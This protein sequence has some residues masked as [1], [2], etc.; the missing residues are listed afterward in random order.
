MTEAGVPL[1]VLDSFRLDG[2][3]A[4][5][6]GAGSGIGLAVAAALAEAGADVACLEVS[7]A[8]A[9]RARAQVEDLG[10][11]SVACV[12]DVAEEAAVEA[13][14][15]EAEEVLGSV[16]IVFANAGIAGDGGGIEALDLEGWRRV[17]DVDLTGTLL[18]VRAAARRMVSRGYGKIVVTGSMYSLRGDP[19]FGSHAYTA[20]KSGVV[21][22]TRSSAITL[23]PHGVRINAILPGYIRTRLADG[24]LFAEDADAV[25]LRRRV[26]ERLPL[27]RV[28][29]AH[30]L[31][32][33]AVFLASPASDYCTGGL[34]PV[35]G[36]WLAT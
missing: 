7:D 22:L 4:F 18:T 25:V 24:A 35:D 19:L 8:G 15:E 14:F 20:A 36:G 5:V 28:G 11:R 31:K 29:E 10:R 17:L 26:E 12:G 23:G 13:A 27:G 32:G 21:G 1:T 30:E 2:R 34:Y 3:A 9:A 33:L 6:T 16:D